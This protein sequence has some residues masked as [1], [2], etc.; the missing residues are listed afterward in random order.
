VKG[1][2]VMIQN[3]LLDFAIGMIAF[4]LVA[5][6][7]VTALQEVIAQLL[8]LRAKTLRAAIGNMLD[9]NKTGGRTTDAFFDNVLIRSLN[10]R[11]TGIGPSYIPRGV[12]TAA[13]KNIGLASSA[14]AAMIASAKALPEDGTAL[15]QALREV[16]NSTAD[17][18]AAF[19]QAVGDWFDAVMERVS[20]L[21]KRKA[22][23]MA[24]WLGLMVAAVANLNTFAVGG[25]LAGNSAARTS[26]AD[27]VADVMN[28]PP[29]F[30]P[31]NKDDRDRL[32]GKMTAV[33]VEQVVPVGWPP[34]PQGQSASAREWH[35]VVRDYAKLIASEGIW[36]GALFGW[37][38][39][40]LATTLGAAF[41][42]DLL[43]RF[44]NIRATGPKPR[45]GKPTEA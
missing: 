23:V 34:A 24:F 3:P 1:A 32:I 9:G 33:S 7:L 21:Y 39:T 12:F 13:V 6:L 43:T 19:D 41:W 17:E 11:T 30:D 25:F 35:D 22:Q 10:T 18:A 45:K 15:Q 27:A 38:V 28:K 4:F 42:F 20:G 37:L 44:V 8:D 31:T 16:A 40:A 36:Q 14:G 5:S 29:P 2:D 26:I